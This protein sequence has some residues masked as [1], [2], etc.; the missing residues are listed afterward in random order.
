VPEYRHAPKLRGWSRHSPKRRCIEIAGLPVCRE[1]EEQLR[2]P[3]RTRKRSAKSKPHFEESDMFTNLQSRIGTLWCS[4][5]HESVMWP[6]HGEFQCR[7][8]GRHYP[9][10]AEAPIGSSEGETA[11]SRTARGR[12]HS[13]TASLS[14]A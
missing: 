8:C 14:R 6:V 12:A 2:Y 7:S 4:L 5:T 1:V 10:F 9:A 13:A 11:V 3:W